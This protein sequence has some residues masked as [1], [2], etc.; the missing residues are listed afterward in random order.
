MNALTSQT[1]DIYVISLTTATERQRSAA[2]QLDKLGLEY[3]I[4]QFERTNTIDIDEYNRKKRLRKYGYD[5]LP[6][7]IGCFLSHRTIWKTVIDRNRPA[8]ILED[9]FLINNQSISE[10]L[11]KI[12]TKINQ[13]KVVRFHAIFEKKVTSHGKIT[14]LDLVTYSGNPSGATAYM[15]SPDAAKT[16][17]NRT[18]EIIIPVDD[19]IDHEWRHG[20]VVYGLLPYPISTT[21]LESEIG[22]RNKPQQNILMKLSTEVNKLPDSTRGKWFKIK[23][24]FYVHQQN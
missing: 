13:L 19:F 22:T 18:K 8:L 2:K 11:N 10:H 17:R 12:L 5:L 20:M 24:M 1:F 3:Q 23:K 9:D 6:G 15:V 7:E 16:L 21:E 4:K 14:N